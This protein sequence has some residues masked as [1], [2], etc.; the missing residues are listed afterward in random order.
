M[1][2]VAELRKDPRPESTTPEDLPIRTRQIPSTHISPLVLKFLGL[3][4]EKLPSGT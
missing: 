3:N 4:G 1:T 2:Q